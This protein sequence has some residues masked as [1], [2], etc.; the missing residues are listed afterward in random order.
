MNWFYVA[1]SF[2]TS[3]KSL[4]LIYSALFT[5]S[6]YILSSHSYMTCINCQWGDGGT[7]ADSILLLSALASGQYPWR[8]NHCKCFTVGLRVMFFHLMTQTVMCQADRIK[9]L[10]I[11]MSV[12]KLTAIIELSSRLRFSLSTNYISSHSYIVMSSIVAFVK[13]ACKSD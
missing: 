1:C 9:E 2:T 5:K 6:C 13:V 11:A 10:E 12:Y 3:S 8:S 4:F 7:R